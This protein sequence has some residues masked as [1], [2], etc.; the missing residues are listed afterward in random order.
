MKTTK[1]TRRLRHDINVAYKNKVDAALSLE[2][3]VRLYEFCKE[4]CQ[5]CKN[6][7]DAS[8]IASRMYYDLVDRKLD[9]T[10]KNGMPIN[11]GQWFTFLKK[12]AEFAIKAYFRDRMRHPMVSLNDPI[13]TPDEGGNGH[14]EFGDTIEDES[15]DEYLSRPDV[16]IEMR[17]VSKV[18]RE[19]CRRNGYPKGVS[20]AIQGIFLYGASISEAVAQSG[21]KPNH[22][23]VV[24][25]RFLTTLHEMGPAVMASLERGS[26]YGFAG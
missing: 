20:K 16:R 12:E 15:Q 7:P 3:K 2:A 22:I 21:L 25:N 9:G 26:D 17:Q 10:F 13:G 23:S 19:I 14:R 4:I 18:V 1:K 6:M 11:E 24:K 5:R 8:E